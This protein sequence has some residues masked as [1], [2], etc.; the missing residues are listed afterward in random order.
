MFLHRAMGNA[1]N[2]VRFSEGLHGEG[3]VTGEGM[4]LAVRSRSA[5]PAPGRRLQPDSH[6]SS[7]AAGI[8]MGARD[9]SQRPALYGEERQ[10]DSSHTAFA[11]PS[12]SSRP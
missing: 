10:R 4:P 6:S 2:F 7:S 5:P 12:G 1:V 9:V 8:W 3:K 11:E